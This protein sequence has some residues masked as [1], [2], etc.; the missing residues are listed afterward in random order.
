MEDGGCTV[1]LAEYEVW[2]QNHIREEWLRVRYTYLEAQH[3]RCGCRS[4]YRRSN[5]RALDAPSLRDKTA[6][7]RRYKR[8]DTHSVAWPRQMM[9]V[10]L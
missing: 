9:S 4:K 7:E 1:L 5:I 3:L 10:W 8:H 6:S 2:R